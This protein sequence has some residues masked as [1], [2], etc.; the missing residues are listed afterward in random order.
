M[1]EGPRGFEQ[2]AQGFTELCGIE[3]G[4]EVALDVS[5]RALEH[6]EPIAQCFELRAREHQ[7]VFAKAELGGSMTSLVV[8]LPAALAAVLTRPTPGGRRR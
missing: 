2:P 7:L 1:N 3:L 6:V 8:P 5:D 4:G